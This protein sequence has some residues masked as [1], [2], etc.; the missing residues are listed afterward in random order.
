MFKKIFQKSALFLATALLLAGCGGAGSGGGSGASGEKIKSMGDIT[1]HD[2]G[3]SNLSTTYLFDDGNTVK[4]ITFKGSG[5]EFGT[6]TASTLNADY[7]FHWEL[8]SKNNIVME[9]WVES[10]NL[11]WDERVKKTETLTPRKT[12][13]GITITDKDA[14]VYKADKTLVGNE[15]TI[16]GNNYVNGREYNLKTDLNA[17]WPHLRYGKTGGSIKGTNFD[18]KISDSRFKIYLVHD[19]GGKYNIIRWKTANGKEVTDDE[20]NVYVWTNAPATI[21]KADI[22]KSN[23]S[24]TWKDQDGQT[25]TLSSGNYGDTKTWY[26]DDNKDLKIKMSSGWVDFVINFNNTTKKVM[27]QPIGGSNIFTSTNAPIQAQ[28]AN[29]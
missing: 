13:A 4:F 27:L 25:L 9:Y 23:L 26:I 2:A 17:D 1:C 20:G 18:W 8:D 10:A 22:T 29:K 7:D 12:D 14:N 16:S 5:G 3:G 28:Y 11:V 21:D 6:K 19:D 24:G 15:L